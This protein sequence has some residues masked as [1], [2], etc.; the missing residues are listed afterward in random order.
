MKEVM[1]IIR[2]NKMNETKKALSK[3]GISSFTAMGSVLGRGKG[4]VDY[5]ILK[6]A[7]EGY[8]EAISQLG[9]GPRLVSKRLLSIV[10]PDKKVKTTVQTIISTNQTGSPGDGKIF[11]LPVAE[12]HKVR[13]AEE[14]D[15]VLDN[16]D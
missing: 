7:E 3:A 16:E 4:L 12:A 2:L 14:G 10:V 9:D 5:K 8:V 13:T 11:I 6:G 1:A 15:D